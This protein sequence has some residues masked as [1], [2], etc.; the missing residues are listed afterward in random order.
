[1]RRCGRQAASLAALSLIR[2]A[3]CAQTRTEAL[4][5]LLGALCFALPTIGERLEEVSAA[6]PLRE[7]ALHHC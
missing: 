4:G 3:F 6:T 2:C 7:L 5:L 1:M